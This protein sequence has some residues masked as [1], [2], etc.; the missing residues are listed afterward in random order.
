V[1]APRC[2]WSWMAEALEDGR[3]HDH[4]RPAFQR[5]AAAC[6]GCRH[7]A[8]ELATLRD[9]MRALPAP[10]PS[11]FDHRRERRRLM[12]RARGLLGAQIRPPRH[13]WGLAAL[14]AAL[15]MATGGAAVHLL[16]GRVVE[17][18]AG[19]TVAVS[20]AAAAPRY[21]IT[22]LED[23]SWTD[24]EEGS[25]ARI[26]LARGSAAFH[27]HR[28]GSGQ[29]F[30]VALPDGEIEVRGTRFVVDVED[31]RTRYVVVMEGKVALRQ[32]GGAE[33]VLI[34]GQRWDAPPA[35]PP[36]TTTTTPPPPVS[37][38]ERPRPAQGG[39]PKALAP[40]SGGPRR[41]AA[42][43]AD[44]PR[45]ETPSSPPPSASPP[46]SP[47]ASA[48]SDL[49]ARGIQAFRGGRYEQAEALW[50]EFLGGHPHD[51]RAEDAMFLCIVGRARRHDAGGAAALAR[52]Y[53]TRF[54]R[55]MRRREA[56][57]LSPRTLPIGAP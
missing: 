18:P 29:R 57:A 36:T 37:R 4:E 44:R 50:R 3:L 27:V 47:P 13:A 22:S 19:N 17:K 10:G 14:A 24:H 6:T 30:L 16:S 56:E 40:P 46:A 28:L 51:A 32:A 23:A 11:D 48:A 25:T 7:A 20:A 35:R 41:L 33:N 12:A 53:L 8:A 45:D 52:E 43:A 42:A 49:F 1:T 5:H 26:A 39:G 2:D 38:V 15:L 9:L 31:H 55:G 21:E 54:P 34:A